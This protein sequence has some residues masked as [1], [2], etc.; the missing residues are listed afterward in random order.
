MIRV[1]A[2]AVLATLLAAQS[3]LDRSARA[4]LEDQG[5]GQWEG[6]LVHVPCVE[7]AQKALQSFLSHTGA[8]RLPAPR[9][10]DTQLAPASPI[11]APDI[12]QIAIAAFS[13]RSLSL[14]G[15]A[16]TALVGGTPP[17]G[18]DAPLAP[19]L[20]VVGIRLA[21]TLTQRQVCLRVV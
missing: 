6:A 4:C 15:E 20:R 9:S 3:Q 14:V 8:L 16:L 1:E 5:Q 7:T 17:P 10:H 18:A 12:P 21:Q 2:E 13:A 11:V 19:P